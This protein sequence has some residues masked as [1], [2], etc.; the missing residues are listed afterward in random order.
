MRAKL[1]EVT[2]A[3]A[4]EICISKEKLRQAALFLVSLFH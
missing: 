2:E 1:R 3:I 4:A